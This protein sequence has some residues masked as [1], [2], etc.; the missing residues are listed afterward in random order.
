MKNIHVEHFSDRIK[1]AIEPVIINSFIQKLISQ[2]KRILTRLN[3]ILIYNS[4][5]NKRNTKTDLLY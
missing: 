1:L 5:F 4:F 2:N 3:I